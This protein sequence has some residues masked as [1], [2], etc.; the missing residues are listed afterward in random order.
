[1][2]VQRQTIS[3]RT[4]TTAHLAQTMSL[5]ALNNTALR[6]KIE[7]ELAANPALELVEEVRCPT[8]SRALPSPGQCPICSRPLNELGEEPLVFLSSR[9][10]FFTPSK[11]PDWSED[12]PE[13]E[14]TPAIEDLP[15]YI[16]RQI[17]AELEP[18]ERPIAAHILTSLNEDGLLD[19]TPLEIARYHFM[20]LAKI[21]RV[22]HLIQHTE[23]YGVGCQ[24]PQEALLVQL[25]VLKETHSIPAKAYQAVQEGLNLISKRRFVEL[26]RMLGIT[27]HQAT[28]IVEFVVRNLNPYPARSHWGESTS[29]QNPR[30]IAEVYFTPDIII[31]NIE[32]NK[33]SGLLVE[34]AT[35]FRGTLH[36]NPLFRQALRQA[37]E[38]KTENWKADMEQATLLVKC[39]QQRNQTLV[40]LLQRLVV[41]QRQFI[42]KGDQHLQP[43]TRAFLA[44]ELDLHESTISRA[45][46]DKAVQMPNGKILPLSSFFDRSLQVRTVLKQII[47][48]EV[49]PFSDAQLVCLLAKEGYDVK[50]RTVAKYRS[51]EGILPAR[52]RFK[53]AV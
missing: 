27:T 43:L 18:D 21:E 5:L 6:Q 3:T 9:E 29:R 24:S 40:R 12:L 50:R 28:E 37:P 15:V 26:G 30:E 32:D 2:L 31:S 7:S 4:V 20:P 47:Q 52:M 44:K 8:C 22:L 14:F 46:S 39:L 45:V 42:L 1:M 25:E 33:A 48:Q 23:P 53:P 35:P 10:E 36:I 49:K 16:L 13:D 38:D 19:T 11:A 51:M 17:A 41:L 34:I